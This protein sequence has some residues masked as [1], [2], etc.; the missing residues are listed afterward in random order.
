M[1]LVL[2][3]FGHDIASLSWHAHTTA[4]GAV[5]VVEQVVQETSRWW[6]SRMIPKR[7]GR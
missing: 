7:R 3:V 6:V 4:P 1:K 5:S 2:N